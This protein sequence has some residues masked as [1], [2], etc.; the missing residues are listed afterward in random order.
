MYKFIYLVNFC[1]SGEA[2]EWYHGNVCKCCNP[3]FLLFT[4]HFGSVIACAF[5]TG[6][7][8][9]FD[10]I[11]DVLLPTSSRTNS[12]KCIGC[13]GSFVSYYN[14]VRSDAM[15]FVYLSGNAYCNAA[16]YCEYLCDK[17]TAT[18]NSQQTSRV[19][20]I[21]AHML[22]SGIVSLLALWVSGV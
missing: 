21:C 2:V 1:V 7:F 5:M 10:F 8:S 13:C 12:N 6:F 17:S 15:G 14:L 9:F 20:R 16:R 22:I 4:K 18:S 11:L 3:L 19:Y